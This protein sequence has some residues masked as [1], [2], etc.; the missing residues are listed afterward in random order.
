ML[1]LFCHSSFLPPR[2]TVITAVRI[3]VHL[4]DATVYKGP[5]HGVKTET[6]ITLCR[7]RR[8]RRASE[9]ATMGGIKP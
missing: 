4:Q 8:W 6:R 3:L 9:F 5:I 7:R 1:F 2:Q